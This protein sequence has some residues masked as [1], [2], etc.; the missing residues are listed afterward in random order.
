MPLFIRGKRSSR[1]KGDQESQL[2]TSSS[3]KRSIASLKKRRKPF[4]SML[5]VVVVLDALGS[6]RFRPGLVRC[7]LKNR[8]ITGFVRLSSLNYRKEKRVTL[9]ELTPGKIF[10]TR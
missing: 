3:T 9:R 10:T 2:V 5:N 4:H 7:D 8:R 1:L 6:K